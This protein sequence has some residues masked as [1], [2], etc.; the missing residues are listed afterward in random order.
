MNILRLAAK[1]EPLTPVLQKAKMSCQDDGSCPKK[2][3]KAELKKR[4]TPL[5]YRVTQEK[6]T[7]SAFSGKYVKVTDEGVFNCIV[8]NSTLFSS[9]SKFDSKSG[10]PSFSDVYERGR[11]AL[12]DDYSHGMQRVEVIC[13]ECGAHLGHVFTDGP[14]PTG[15]RYCI[16]SAALDF[17][18][19]EDKEN[20]VKVKSEL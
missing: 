5:Q 11:V 8:C 16:N 15:L 1:K 9:E 17:V 7:E 12:I 14:E 20:H 3:D 10:W 2:I 4:L 13:S 18:K 19:T 6:G